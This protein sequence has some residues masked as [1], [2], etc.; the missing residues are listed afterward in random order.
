MHEVMIIIRREFLERV[1]SRAFFVGTLLFPVFMVGVFLLPNL[2]NRGSA[3]RSLVLV[4]NAPPPIGDRFAALLTAAD[5]VSMPSR[6]NGISR[7]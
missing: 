5:S 2:G 1:R 7:P 4:D 6:L 3:H